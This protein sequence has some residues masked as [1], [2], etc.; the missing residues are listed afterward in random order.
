M[1]SAPQ[2]HEIVQADVELVSRTPEDRCIATGN[3]MTFKHEHGPATTREQSR[4]SE[5]ASSGA[6]YDG[7]ERTSAHRLV[8][9][10][11]R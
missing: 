2:S 10:A 3:R 1:P 9:A 7:I 6:E 11:P 5:A 4:R 8:A